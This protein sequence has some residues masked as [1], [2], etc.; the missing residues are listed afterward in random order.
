MDPNETGI[1]GE[2][3]VNSAV[4]RPKPY[5]RIS[6]AG[7]QNSKVPISP[8]SIRLGEFVPAPIEAKKEAT[9]FGS[10]GIR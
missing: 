5:F 1:R 9:L 8:L 4:M 6:L 7:R 10:V 2:S 3:I